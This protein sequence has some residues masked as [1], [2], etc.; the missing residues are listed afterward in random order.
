[1]SVARVS[2]VLRRFAPVRS[3]P[4]EIRRREIGAH[5]AHR[6]IARVGAE[7]RVVE[8]RAHEDRALRR[9]DDAHAREIRVGE[10]HA[11]NDHGVHARAHAASRA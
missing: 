10:V 4:L 2:F 11:L 8:L 3:A 1:M 9:T 6:L 5:H 7:V